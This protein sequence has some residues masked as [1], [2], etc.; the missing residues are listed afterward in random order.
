MEAIILP[1]KKVYAD[2]I[3]SGNKKYEFRKRLCKKDI[4]KIYL[5]ETS[6]VRM[7]TGEVMIESKIVCEKEELWTIAEDKAGIEKESYYEYF[8]GCTNVCAYKLSTSIK[9]DKPISLNEFGI[10]YIIQSFAYV[11]SDL[12]IEKRIRRLAEGR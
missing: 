11:K 8:N 5:Y 4:E 1:I 7:V 10:N 3:Y 9:Y 12:E 6:P 2:L